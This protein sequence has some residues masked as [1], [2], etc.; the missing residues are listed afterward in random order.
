M[1]E[2]VKIIKINKL[3]LIPLRGLTVFPHM[4][5]HFDI[6]RDKS[7]KALEKAMEDNQLV[8]LVTQKETAMDDPET[9]DIY[10]YGTVSKI[11]QLLRLPGKTIRVLIEGLE[12]GRI[13]SY[14]KTQPF[15]EAEIERIEPVFNSRDKKKEE[16]LKRQAVEAFEEYATLA[17]RVSPETVFSI[18]TTEDADKLSDLIIGSI[19][20]K[21]EAKQQL[22]EENNPVKRL[23][24]ML[25]LIFEEIQILELEKD[26]S[27]KVKGQI[28]EM[29]KQYYLKE[30]LKVIQ[31]ELGENQPEDDE[32]NEYYEAL[33]DRK[34]PVEVREKI[35]KELNRLKKMSPMSAESSVIR[36][37]VEWLIQMPWD[38][39]TQEKLD[40]RKARFILERDHYGLAK[41]KE[42]IIEYIAARKMSEGFNAPILCLVGPPGVGKTSIAK[43]IAEAVNRNYVRMSLGG[44]RDEAEIRGHRRT[45]VGSMPGR[46]AKAIV[47]A[48]SSNPLMLLDE[49]DKMSSDFRGDPASAMLEVLDSEQNYSFRDHYLEVSLDLRQVM[50][51]TTANSLDTVPRALVDRMEV[52]EVSGYTPEEK[53]NIAKKYLLPKLLGKYGLNKRQ[54][55][56]G[57]PAMMDI[58]NGYTRESGVRN[59]ERELSAILRKA[60]TRLVEQNM[61]GV[62]VNRGHLVEFLGPVRYEYEKALKKN[63]IGIARGLA[64]TPVGGDTLSI[65]VNVMPGTGSLEL[66]GRLGD[67]M[68]ES[69]KAAMG[70]IRS[71]TERFALEKDFYKKID[72]HVHVPEGAVPKDGPSAGITLAT[73]IIS[74]LMGIPVFGFVAMTGEITLRGR[75]LPIGGL[76][77]KLTAARRAG[78]TKV[79]LPLA[80]DKDLSEVPGEILKAMEIVKAATMEDVLKHALAVDYAKNN[81]DPGKSATKPAY[82]KG[83]LKEGIGNGPDIRA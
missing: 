30:Q 74:A 62:V 50:F 52:I 16:A 28:D 10:E 35:E 61:E 59:L 32:L 39:S 48:E 60:T 3:P 31:D 65:E 55:K 12:R 25:P 79:I 37:Y 42:R 64:W 69:A 4:T 1:Q 83:D 51:I 13:V 68:K 36:T 63:E 11:K 43:S 20:L 72:I 19:S 41:V 73:A 33:R 54:L 21:T 38:K 57:N 8:F 53:L 5:I 47:Q 77:E 75:V 82:L 27:T 49:I 9:G 46:I 24:K 44:V 70:Y 26:I 17:G 7:I 34:F 22:L 66:T 80:N 15:F 58:I 14:E 45:Y 40:I 71:M 81:R 76:K 6:G 23:D 18:I 78:I 56:I 67:V 2:S 29:Q